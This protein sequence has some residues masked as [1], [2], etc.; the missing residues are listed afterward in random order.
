MRRE[1]GTLSSNLREIFMK[2]RLASIAV[3]VL[4]LTA[5]KRAGDLPADEVLRRATLQSVQLT[6]AKYTALIGVRL[7]KGALQGEGKAEFEGQLA[8]GGKQ[9]STNVTADGTIILGVSKS[10]FHIVADVMTELGHDAYFRLKEATIDPV[11]AWGKT[12]T[13]LVGTW[14][15][16]PGENRGTLP[17]PPVTPDP[18]FLRMQAEVVTVTTD[19]G[20][21]SLHGRDVY[22][23]DVAIDPEKLIGFLKASAAERKEAFDEAAT[24]ADLL[25]YDAKGELW[26]DAE[27]FVLHRLKW[28][29]T[30]KND[31][32][33][34][35]LS[36][37]VELRDHGQPVTI[38]PPETS[39]VLNTQDL[40]KNAFPVPPTP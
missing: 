23:Y 1:F 39:K 21:V 13:D 19:H 24:R 6:S 36:I 16:V 26:I 7:A 38:A 20:L 37:D 33:G 9:T 2:R 15:R 25:R 22:H 12:I 5:C 11:P 14:W 35:R 8:D 31:P 27:S 17:T 32:D 28:M 29:I 10:A 4:L 30:T 18:K 40:L 34:L 3:L